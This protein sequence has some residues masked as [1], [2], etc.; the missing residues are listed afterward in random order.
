[1]RTKTTLSAVVVTA[2][3]LAAT[4]TATAVPQSAAEAAPQGAVLTYGTTI[5]LHNLWNSD[6][7]Y[8]DSNGY[9]QQPGAYL[10]VSTANTP[11][12]GPGTGSWKV[13]SATGK[14]NGAPVVSGDIVYLVNQWDHGHGGYLDTNGRSTRA[15]ARL[16]VS[17]T[18]SATRIAGSTVKWHV[19]DK[20]SSPRDGKVR[21]DDTVNLLNDYRSAQGG[22]LDTNGYETRP[23]AKLA[24]STSYYSDR[25]VGT[26]SWKIGTL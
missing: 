19:L 4:A 22:F 20:T 8:L 25:G 21:I 6:G 24:V 7:G 15:G 14:N 16:N 17:T 26:G 12:R 10:A 18:K 5:T 11:T 13:L 2:A 9:S 1:M 23:G 3:A